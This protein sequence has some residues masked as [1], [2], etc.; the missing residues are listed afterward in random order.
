MLDK[1]ISRAEMAKIAVKLRG[2]DV[3]GCSGNVYVDVTGSLGDLCSYLEIAASGG[4]ISLAHTTFRP[5]DTISRAEMVKMLL[6]AKD[7]SPS[8]VKAGF[9]DVSPSLGDLEGFI[10]A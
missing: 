3:I 8:V 5:Y 1:N 9:S 2:N 7:I 4:I 10:N 6:A